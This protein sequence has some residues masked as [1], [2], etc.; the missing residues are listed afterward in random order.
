MEHTH[1]ERRRTTAKYIRDGC[2]LYFHIYRLL[3]ECNRLLLLILR[4]ACRG[5]YACTYGFPVLDDFPLYPE[6]NDTKFSAANGAA[7]V[8][9]LM[10]TRSTGGSNLIFPF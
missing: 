3:F 5:S 10:T 4:M 8:F 1:R 7:L 6:H 2:T 9:T